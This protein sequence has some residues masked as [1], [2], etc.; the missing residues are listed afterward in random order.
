MRRLKYRQLF[1]SVISSRPNWRTKIRYDRRGV[2][3][4]TTYLAGPSFTLFTGLS[5]LPSP[6]PL[7]F[8]PLSL[9]FPSY[10]LP[11]P[12]LRNKPLGVYGSSAVSFP[13]GSEEGEYRRIYSISGLDRS[14]VT[15][16]T[17]VVFMRA[18]VWRRL[19]VSYCNGPTENAGLENAEPRKYGKPTNTPVVNCSSCNH[20]LTV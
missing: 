9:P 13:A 11:L 18:A 4:R 12:S 20:G 5:S 10:L 1:A 16:S 8:P 14:V 19:A 2:K 6:L 3:G 17:D 15:L 7:P